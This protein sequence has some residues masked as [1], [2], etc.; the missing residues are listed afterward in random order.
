MTNKSYINCYT[1]YLHV[2][3]DDTVPRKMASGQESRN[4]D[5]AKISLSHYAGFANN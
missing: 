5:Q 1:L 3:E 4:T 2:I